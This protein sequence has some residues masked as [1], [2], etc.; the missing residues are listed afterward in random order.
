MSYFRSSPGAPERL[1]LARD[2]VRSLR[3]GHPWVFRDA[4][5]KA[6]T[7]APGDLVEL[8]DKKGR[9]VAR[10]IDNKVERNMEDA[11]DSGA[12]LDFDDRNDRQHAENH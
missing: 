9:I 11:E 10:G 8:A 5:R 6:P 12:P 1:T 4:L 7:G 2:L 3:R